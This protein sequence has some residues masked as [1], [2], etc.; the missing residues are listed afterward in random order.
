MMKRQIQVCQRHLQFLRKLTRKR[1]LHASFRL[2]CHSSKRGAL[3]TETRV[4]IK[5]ARALERSWQNTERR[6][7]NN[8]TTNTAASM[9]SKEAPVISSTI[10]HLG[11]G[12]Q[13]GQYATT[14]RTYTANDVE[15]FASCVQDFNP[16]HT[17]MDWETMVDE[18]PF[19]KIHH[20][21]DLIRFDETEDSDTT[22]TTTTTLPI[23]HG[24]LVSSIFSS[25]FATLG[26]GCI[27]MN[28]TLNFEKPVYI[29]ATVV[30]TIEIEKIRKWR[31]G[32]VV[33]Q[34]RT[35]VTVLDKDWLSLRGD[36]QSSDENSTSATMRD[37]TIDSRKSAGVTAVE[38]T[39]NVWLPSG[40]AAS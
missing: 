1:D 36:D 2:L 18:N 34:C 9:T 4:S 39:A 10:P 40:Y 13:V 27:Y 25:M 29:N 30:G 21:N 35:E 19:W 15:R 14:R 11:Q 32:G 24:M 38:G 8:D 33:V 22:T 12:V 5:N 3:K 6:L 37:R 28:Q 26:P 7:H 31:K 17:A 20:E 23:V 16:L